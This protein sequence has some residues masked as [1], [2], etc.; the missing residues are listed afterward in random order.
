MRRLLE[1]TQRNISAPSGTPMMPPITKG[2]TRDHC[3]A[4]RNFPHRPSLH[5]KA[6]GDDQG[7][8]LDRRQDVQPYRRGND[9]KS[10]PGYAGDKGRGESAGGKQGEIKS[11]RAVHGIPRRFGAYECTGDRATLGR[12]RG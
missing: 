12:L 5:D 7:S 1:L 6:E 4:A 3:S 2:S 8:C 11:L 10:E 9:A